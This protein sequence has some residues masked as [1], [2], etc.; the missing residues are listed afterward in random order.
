MNLSLNNFLRNELIKNAS[1]H[2]TESGGGTGGISATM[3]IDPADHPVVG[4]EAKFFFSFSDP[5][6]LFQLDHC[7]CTIFLFKDQDIIDKHEVVMPSGFAA[8]LTTQPL[9]TKTFTEPGDYYI[10][11]T[12]QPKKGFNFDVFALHFDVKVSEPGSPVP[13]AQAA[14]QVHEHTEHVS[15]SPWQ[16]VLH[17]EHLSHAIIFGGGLIASIILFIHGVKQNRSLKRKAAETK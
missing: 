1:A 17:Y 11:F 4:Q 8:S 7:N 12:G 5:D 3:H 10:H 9:F 2:E 13:Q 16:H 15:A 6:K 14:T